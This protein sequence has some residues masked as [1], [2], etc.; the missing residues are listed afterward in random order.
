MNDL[1]LYLWLRKKVCKN[2]GCPNKFRFCDNYY[3]VFLLVF[4]SNRPICFKMLA[5]MR[6]QE[7]HEFRCSKKRVTAKIW[8]NRFVAAN[9]GNLEL[10]DQKF[11]NICPI[12]RCHQ[13]FGQEPGCFV[14]TILHYWGAVYSTNCLAPRYH[15]HS[16]SSWN[17]EFNLTWHKL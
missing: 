5:L 6:S 12:W 8:Q 9:M 11:I 15:G 7:G 17:H 4:C 2:Q 14:F 10:L 1:F 13:Q 3:G 16:I